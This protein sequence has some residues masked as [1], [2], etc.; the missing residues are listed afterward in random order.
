MLCPKPRPAWFD[1][2]QI[3]KGARMRTQRKMKWTRSLS[4]ASGETVSRDVPASSWLALGLSGGG[5]PHNPQ[6]PRSWEP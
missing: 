1:W 3:G 5:G 2:E 6:L 4:L